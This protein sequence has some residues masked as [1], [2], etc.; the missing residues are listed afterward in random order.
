NSD[1][2]TPMELTDYSDRYLADP[3]KALSGVA[4]VI[5]GGERKYSMRVWLDRERL[6]AQGLAAQ[7]VEEALRR[8]NLDSPGGRIEST[9]REFTVLAQ[10][11]LK[12]AEE[13]N[14]MIIR[15]VNGYPVRLRD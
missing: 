3:L 6:A 13:F 1:R 12:S 8:Q 14:N 7:D 2:H 15:E 9:E 11:D 10:T 5:I 4:A